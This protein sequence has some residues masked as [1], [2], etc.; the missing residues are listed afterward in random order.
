MS[1]LDV[2]AEVFGLQHLIGCRVANIYDLDNKSFIIKL[3]RPELKALLLLESGVRFHI[4]EFHHTKPTAPGPVAAKLR[5]HL[6]TRRLEGIRQLGM[7]R[8]VDFSFTS[9]EGTFHLL[10]ELYASGNLIL[11]DQDFRIAML[12]RSH[13]FDEEVKYA[14]HEIYPF[15]YAANLTIGEEL[16]DSAIY[17]KFNELDSQT[18]AKGK[19]RQITMKGFLSTLCPYMH[20]AFAGYCLRE[21]G[22]TGVNAKITRANLNCEI[23]RNASNVAVQVINSFENTKVPG[24]ILSKPEMF[25]CVP[26]LLESTDEKVEVKPFESFDRALDT[27]F[28][29]IEESKEKVEE[30]KAEEK[31]WQKKNKIENDQKQRLEQLRNEQESFKYRAEVIEQ[32][33]E[34]VDSVINIMQKCL[35]TGVAWT[36]L[37]R[38]VKEEQ[39]NDNV[40]AQAIMEFK[41]EFNVI[42]LSLTDPEGDTLQVEVDLTKNAYQNAT[43]YYESKK[44]AIVKEQ[45]T[46]EAMQ[47]VLKQAEKKAKEELK[48]HAMK[49]GTGVRQ[50]RKVYWWEKFDWFVS[51]DNY[52]VIS[53]RD[54]QQNELIVKRYMRKGDIYVHA[55]FS[56]AS[57]TLVKNPSGEPIPGRTLDQA[58][59]MCVCRSQAW[60]KKIL[61][62][63][64]WVYA[65]Q[66][67]K[68]AP[69]GMFLGSGSFM[70]RGKKNF[71]RPTKL[72]MGF[73][74]LFK[75]G[76][77]S[78]AHHLGERKLNV[79][80]GELV[81]TPAISTTSWEEESAELIEPAAQEEIPDEPEEPLHETII[82][83]EAEGEA[84]EHEEEQVEEDKEEPEEAEPEEVKREKPAKPKKKQNQKKPEE[85]KPQPVKPMSKTKKNKLKKIKEK[86]GEQDDEERA[87]ALK[88]LGSKLIKE[89]QPKDQPAEVVEEVKAAPVFPEDNKEVKLRADEEKQRVREKREK[90]EEEK[91][92]VREV[93]QDENLLSEDELKGIGELDSLTGTPLDHDS[94]HFCVPMCAPYSAVSN[95]RCKVKLL[96]GN[97]K[98]GKAVKLVTGIW[99]NSSELPDSIKELIRSM[100]ESELLLSIMGNVSVAAAGVQKMQKDMKKKAK[101][102]Q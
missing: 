90:I 93:L 56:G 65:D 52:L 51:S 48:K 24:F 35:S 85:T 8:V 21:A 15:N 59:M 70:I 86:Y 12:L 64:W 2:R 97:L 7:D 68:T 73:S 92:Q 89:M 77:D 49:I 22:V 102:K 27:Y 91:R 16:P 66:V 26:V 67:S 98:K 50:I 5:K 84:V 57:S 14:K 80:E 54:S 45:K 23:F 30:V 41:L 3:A 78:L 13:Q 58:G 39:D 75:L 74:L 71:L 20:P 11:T 63:A 31:V 96:P 34:F 38:M 87:L 6:K 94:M 43:Y 61:S 28:S 101:R 69:S 33:C 76:E 81:L 17:E 79:E 46:E 62:T 10:L 9:N 36:Q 42:V 88:L 19:K 32:H 44:S 99:L 29:Q 40:Y 1:S 18:D 95:Y 55:D 47:S 72:E 83:A 4:T 37:W 25:D 82:E 100:T 60:N 53:G